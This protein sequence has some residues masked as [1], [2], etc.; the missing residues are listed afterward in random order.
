M[1]ASGDMDW[2]GLPLLDRLVE[3]DEP[4]ASEEV[5]RI[6]G[7]R[8]VQ[9]IGSTL[10]PTGV[11]LALSG[12]RLDEAVRR[13]TVRR[14]PVWA[15]G[16]RIRQAR[17]V[18]DME[19][20]RFTDPR[21][22]HDLLT[23]EP[24]A[25]W[26]GPVLVLRT[27]KSSGKVLRIDG[28]MAELD[29]L[30]DSGRFDLDLGR[31]PEHT[32]EV[33]V[34]R[35]ESGEDGTQAAV[36]DGYGEHGIWVRGSHDHANP[37]VAG[38]IGTGRFPMMFARVS[39]AVWVERRLPLIDAVRQAEATRLAEGFLEGRGLTVWHPAEPERCFRYVN[40]ISARW[41]RKER[42]S[43]PPLRMRLRCWYDVVIGVPGGARPVVLHQEGLRGDEVR[44]AAQ[45][46]ARW[47]EARGFGPDHLAQIR[48][49]R[50]SG[51]QPRPLSPV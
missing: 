48:E 20:R 21:D 2:A 5:A 26:R 4:L 29:E 49:V 6:V 35:I 14:R 39:E 15:A 11:T 1:T 9:G 42:H 22:E 3:S 36:P 17:H 7:A 40:W 38:A 51:K 24:G 18:L 41:D 25:D 8:S 27:L 10:R 33:F 16:D 46:I 12:I 47:R 31:K 30:L 45:A 28:G 50:I 32:G 44:T 34:E 43:A 23:A 13:R 37:R 19:R